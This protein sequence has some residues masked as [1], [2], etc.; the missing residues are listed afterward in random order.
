MAVVVIGGVIASTVLTL[1]V[2]PAAYSL[3]ARLQSHRHDKDLRE[4]LVEL[5]EIGAGIDDPSRGDRPSGAP[6]RPGRP[7]SP[8]G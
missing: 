5:G 8:I 4:A 3:L 7:G 2:V 1:F 6:V